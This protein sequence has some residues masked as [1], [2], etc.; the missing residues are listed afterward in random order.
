MSG[1]NNDC[2]SFEICI[3]VAYPIYEEA[4]TSPF[5][6]NCNLKIEH[7]SKLYVRYL[8]Y[9]LDLGVVIPATIAIEIKLFALVR[10]ADITMVSQHVNVQRT[11][12]IFN[13]NSEKYVEYLRGKPAICTQ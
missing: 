8:Y 2:K 1:N 5:S 4:I 9:L 3:H 10:A 11:S 12:F 13:K 6:L 7:D